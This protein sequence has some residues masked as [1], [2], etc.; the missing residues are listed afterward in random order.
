[1]VSYKR[2]SLGKFHLGEELFLLGGLI[3]YLKYSGR[4]PSWFRLEQLYSTGS[5]LHTVLLSPK[6]WSAQEKRDNNVIKSF[7]FLNFKA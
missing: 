6:A 5:H 2:P 3:G 7:H 4:Y 1:M